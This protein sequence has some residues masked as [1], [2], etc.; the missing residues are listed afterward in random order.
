VF[1]D[2][3]IAFLENIV[4]CVLTD[5]GIYACYGMS[6]TRDRDFEDRGS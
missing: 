3:S 2:R 6:P 5:L 1:I 4:D